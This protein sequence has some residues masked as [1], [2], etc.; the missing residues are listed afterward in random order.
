MTSS[1]APIAPP[2][3][4]VPALAAAKA[5][6]VPA[7]ERFSTHY[8]RYNGP[9][10]AL[11]ANVTTH[12]AAVRFA[13]GS[14]LAVVKAFS[15]F[16]KGWLNEAIAW[17]L[18]SA[19]GVNVPPRAMLLAAAPSDL[20]GATEPELVLANKNLAMHG[21]VVLWCA[22]R[23]DVK[24]P[25]SVWSANWATQILRGES[26][27]RLAA[28][29]GWIG[30]CDRHRDNSPYWKAR[31]VIAAIDHERMAFGQD[32]IASSP[33]H[34]DVLGVH[35]TALLEVF[36]AAR[37]SKA[38]VNKQAKAIEAG[39]VTFS[40]GHGPEL[41]K[42]RSQIEQFVSSHASTGAAANLLTF[43]EDRAKDS[44]ISGRVGVIV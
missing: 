1:A 30:N 23:L 29:D 9:V 5:S 19:L 18:G 34:Q 41:A 31:G 7:V 28:F 40:K 13:E 16:D 21:P 10:G 35:G 4:P 33:L 44:Y 3:A 15:V 25:Q 39:L 37:K 43:L 11:G 27:Q 38:I 20:A 36:H 17:V 32:W 24:P 42:L 2:P 12:T 6:T 22:S 26:G 14:G 8:E